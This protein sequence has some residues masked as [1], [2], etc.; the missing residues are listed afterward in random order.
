MRVLLAAVVALACAGA[1]GNRLS[2]AQYATTLGAIR[3]V[4]RDHDTGTPLAHAAI[5]L[6]A[7]GQLYAT[8]ASSGPDGKFDFRHLAAGM[9]SINAEF[10]GQ[11]I[12]IEDI[13][14]IAGATVPVDLTFTLGRPDPIHLVFG[15]AKLG[16]IDRYR[17]PGL[18]PTV[19]VLE[20]SVQDSGSHAGVG[21]AVVTAVG[22]SGTL[23]MVTDDDGRYRFPIVAPG[24][25]V[26]SAYYSIA[27]RGQFEVRRSNVHAA[28]GEAVIVP[29]WIESAGQ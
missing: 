11:P 10:A 16:A 15:D 7:S 20:G 29:L 17:P 19:A 5:H 14:V 26:V 12:D 3:G 9:Y 2:P 13:G 25:Y 23:Q 18:A 6:R 27:N 8:T 28:G 22:P 1:C 4:A 24:I 21:G